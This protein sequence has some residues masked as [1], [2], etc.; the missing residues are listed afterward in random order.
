LSNVTCYQIA[1][2]NQNGEQTFYVS[3]GGSDGSSS[4]LE[5]KDHLTDHPDTFFNSHV[6]VSCLT[7]DTWAEKYNVEFVDLLWL[8]MQGFELDMLK[9]SKKILPTVKAIHTEVSTKET[10]K[11]VPLYSVLRQYLESKGFKVAVE[12][13]PPGADMGNV[14]F[15]RS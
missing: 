8:D 4:L 5:P 3:E 6:L 14:F 9:A 13:I 15:V 2:S 7:L 12:A 10:Y 1:L 11:G